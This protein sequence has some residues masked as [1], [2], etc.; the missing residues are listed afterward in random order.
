MTRPA[1]IICLAHGSRHPQADQAVFEIAERISESTGLPAFAAFLDFHPATLTTVA[2]RV[3][4]AGYSEAVVVPLLF[5]QAFHARFDVPAAIAE[6]VESIDATSSA[7]LTLHLTDGLGT[8]ADMEELVADFTAQYLA[9]SVNS[10]TAGGASAENAVRTGTAS[11][12][13]VAGSIDKLALY[14]VGSSQPG[15]NEAVAEF[16]G[17]VGARLNMR[18]TRAFVATGDNPGRDTEALLEFADERTVTVPLFVSP[19]LLWD[20]AKIRMPNGR[21]CTRHLGD[22][23]APVVINRAC[24][25]LQQAH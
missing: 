19:G 8:G 10:G 7:G 2:H 6:A 22:A 14:S 5:T 1:P 21:K 15:A 13:A 25:A 3:V 9:E 16:A 17:R 11:A 4:A 18:S 24:R 20:K 12:D 23:I